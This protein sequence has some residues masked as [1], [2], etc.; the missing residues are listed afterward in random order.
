MQNRPIFRYHLGVLL[1]I[2]LIPMFNDIKAIPGALFLLLIHSS[3]IGLGSLYFKLVRTKN[4]KFD[5]F[6]SC[7]IIFLA[8]DFFTAGFK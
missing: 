5:I 2:L 8:T 1:L 3:S 6:L 7:L 4:L